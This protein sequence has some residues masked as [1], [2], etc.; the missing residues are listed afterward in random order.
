MIG[1][2]RT[3]HEP[4]SPYVP[5]HANLK[6]MDKP[7]EFR[8]MMLIDNIRY[9]YFISYTRN[10]IESETL[11]YYPNNYPVD[12]FKRTGGNSQNS[13]IESDKLTDTTSYLLF[14]SEFNDDIC[15]RVFKEIT[16]I[17]VIGDYPVLLEYSLS[18]LYADPELKPL[19]LDAMDA[20]DLG[21]QDMDLTRSTVPVMS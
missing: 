21:L 1:K 2:K 13:L 10:R 18:M 9:D 19:V 3:Q 5:F 6:N 17:E 11:V 20:A 7:T 15:N 16:D 14:A 8:M 4:I 12:V